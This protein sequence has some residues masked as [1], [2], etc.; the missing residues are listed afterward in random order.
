MIQQVSGIIACYRYR[1][2]LIFAKKRKTKP[3]VQDKDMD[4]GGKKNGCQFAC[5]WTW[6]CK[7]KL[8]NAHIMAWLQ[9][10]LDNPETNTFFGN[11]YFFGNRYISETRKFEKSDFFNYTV[12]K[13]WSFFG[14]LYISETR[15]KSGN[16]DFFKNY[17]QQS[18]SGI[19]QLNAHI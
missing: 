9:Q 15:K 11:W 19:Q 18:F 5:E 13:A 2:F 7:P 10:E 1:K 8:T 6:M 17:C 4:S 3:D 12:N 16:Q 14:N